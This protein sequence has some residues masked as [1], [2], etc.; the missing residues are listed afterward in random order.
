MNRQLTQLPHAHIRHPSF[1]L[2]SPPSPFFFRL[3]LHL[4]CTEHVNV[5]LQGVVVHPVL[6]PKKTSRG[7]STAT[8]IEWARSK[9]MSDFSG[10][11]C[12]YTRT[13]RTIVC[14]V[15]RKA[16]GGVGWRGGRNTELPT[17]ERERERKTNSEWHL[18]K[19]RVDKKKGGG[20]RRE[21]KEGNRPAFAC[22]C[23]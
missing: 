11:S 1:L 21:M 13:H 15:G 23:V 18:T 7:S 8:N 2:P 12:T 4:A 14:S 10:T 5:L 20:R 6:L 3:F 9:T 17:P 16:E 19:A 22:L